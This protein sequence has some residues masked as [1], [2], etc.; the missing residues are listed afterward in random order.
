MIETSARCPEKL[1]T[2]VGHGNPAAPCWFLGMEE[3]IDERTM[4]L[5]EN[6][7][8]RLQHFAPIMDLHESVRLLGCPIT[9]TSRPPTSTWPWM[10]K[11]LRGLVERA[12][13][14]SD[15]AEARRFIVERLGK[16]DGDAF[17]AELLP[18][19]KQ[20]D[21]AWPA[22]YS[23]WWPTREEYEREVL[24]PRIAFLQQQMA[25]YTPRWVIAH[26]KRHHEAYRRLFPDY[27]WAEKGRLEVGRSSGSHT[28][29][30]LAPFFGNGQF[31]VSDAAL[32]IESFAT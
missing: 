11:I 10:A 29:V 20:S 21:A 30:A 23:R 5:D 2:F 32:L 31:G 27:Q 19:P 13:D 4:S 15:P 26:G 1:L 16:M 12:E 9:R 3:G 14:W 6:I 18:L 17:I 24:P 8:V 25:T 7:M 28:L 22:L